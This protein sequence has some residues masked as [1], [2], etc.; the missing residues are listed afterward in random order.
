MTATAYL[1][2]NLDVYQSGTRHRVSI[3]LVPVNRI[4]CQVYRVRHQARFVRDKLDIVYKVTAIGLS[5]LKFALGGA[6]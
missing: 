5:S 6:K 4:V 2:I 3:P 1:S